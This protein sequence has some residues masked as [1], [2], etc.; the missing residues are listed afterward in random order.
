METYLTEESHDL[1]PPAGAEDAGKSI[2]PP[3]VSLNWTAGG[4][5]LKL[6]PLRSPENQ[7][8][9]FISYISLGLGRTGYSGHHSSLLLSTLPQSILQ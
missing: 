1:R 2:N 7:H 8:A 3:T 6:L 5:K 9:V 4:R